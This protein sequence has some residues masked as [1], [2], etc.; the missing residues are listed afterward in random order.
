MLQLVRKLR[1]SAA[2]KVK[3]TATTGRGATVP[4]IR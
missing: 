1:F 4:P 2:K 3:I